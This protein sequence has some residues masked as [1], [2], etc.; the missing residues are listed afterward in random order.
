[1]A[2]CAHHFLLP[3]LGLLPEQRHTERVT[4][5]GFDPLSCS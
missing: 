3:A 1:M 5:R 2:L 4:R